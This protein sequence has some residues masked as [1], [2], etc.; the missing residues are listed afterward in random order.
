MIPYVEEKLKEGV[1]HSLFAAGVRGITDEPP[2][3]LGERCSHWFICVR[4]CCEALSELIELETRDEELSPHPDNSERAN[5]IS[6][7]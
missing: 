1:C 4:D 5:H 7:V 6:V 2:Q 3:C